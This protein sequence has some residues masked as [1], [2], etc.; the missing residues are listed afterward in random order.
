MWEHIVKTEGGGA[1]YGTFRMKVPGGWVVKQVIQQGTAS[2]A[3]CFVPDPGHEWK[4]E[5][6]KP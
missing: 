3:L 4:L 5:E 6:P 1:L 2:V